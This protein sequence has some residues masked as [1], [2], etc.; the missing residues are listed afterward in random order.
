MLFFALS[1]QE[2]FLIP[3]SIL[4]ATP[5]RGDTIRGNQ[6]K[7][8]SWKRENVKFALLGQKTRVRRESQ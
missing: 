4:L 6:E 2:E 3:N 1:C 7:D 8:L 5:K